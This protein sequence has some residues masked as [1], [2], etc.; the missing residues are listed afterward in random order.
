MGKDEIAL[1]NQIRKMLY[2]HISQYPGV[3]FSTL[4]RFYELNDSTLR[5]HLKYLERAEK[6]SSQ[7]KEGILHYY[8]FNR[9]WNNQNQQNPDIYTHQLTH[10]QNNILNTI[11]QYPGINQSELMS[12]TA[13]KRHILSYNL[14]QLINQG[15]IRK[16]NNGRNVCYEHITND[17]LEYE[18]LKILA[19]KFLNNELDEQTYLRLRGMLKREY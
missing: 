7:L 10:E 12:Q 17:L 18:M 11:K 6:I 15:I 3:S 4:K 9:N 14:S 1:E 2:K 13:L 8:L 19:V 16:V 5:Y